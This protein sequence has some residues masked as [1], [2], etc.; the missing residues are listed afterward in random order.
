[1]LAFP[2]FHL[3]HLSSLHLSSVSSQDTLLDKYFQHSIDCPLLRPAV[4]RQVLTR[5]CPVYSQGDVAT[6]FP[7]DFL[8]FVGCE[9]ILDTSSNFTRRIFQLFIPSARPSCLF[10]VTYCK[11]HWTPPPLS[12]YE[13]YLSYPVASSV[14]SIYKSV[15]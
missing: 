14:P 4:Y 12:R 11:E 8:F 9:F 15:G 6:A 3:H 7:D 2:T 13:R 5:L 10:A 1:M